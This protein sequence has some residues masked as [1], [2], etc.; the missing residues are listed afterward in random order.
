MSTTTYG[1]NGVPRISGTLRAHYIELPKVIYQA[2]GMVVMGRRIKSILFSTDVAI[3]RNCNADA[4][5]AVYPFTPQQTIQQA[6]INNAV[7]PVFVGVGG[8]MTKGIRSAIIAQ[9]AEAQGAYG[10]VV[11]SP[12][13]DSNIRLI[14]RTIDIPVIATIPDAGEDIRAR[15]DAGVSILN[16]AAGARTAEVVRQ[17]REKFLKVP[18]IAT[19]GN[20]DESILDTIRAGANCIVWT[21]PSTGQIIGDMMEEY[22]TLRTKNPEFEL[23]SNDQTAAALENLV[24]RFTR[25]HDLGL[26]RRREGRGGGDGPAAG[27]G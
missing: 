6:V 7:A 1:E 13:S 26:R 18:I 24:E 22:R 19:G 8:G 21:P 23:V 4:V 20:T 2:K 14:R 3:I 17:V 15:L 10:V 16:V 25:D 11:N 9:D 27:D 5:L 12:M